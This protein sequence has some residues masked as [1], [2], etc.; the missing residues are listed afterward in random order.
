MIRSLAVILIPLVV[1]AVLFTDLPKDKAV[2]EVDWRPVLTAARREAPFPVLAPTNLPE[3]WVAT[4]VDWVRKGEPY[5]D[6]QPSARNL[7]SLGFLTPDQV[8]IG[9][10]QGDGPPTDLVED[11]TRAGTGDGRS[12]VD[13]QAWERRLSPDGRT[14][15]LVR[16]QPQVTTIVSGD[17]PYEALEAYAVTLAPS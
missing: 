5:R 11:Q 7:W 9:L 1:I 3:G 10:D 15:S 13:G 16:T 14:R 6:G 4:Q 8:F 12:T 2:A 17:L